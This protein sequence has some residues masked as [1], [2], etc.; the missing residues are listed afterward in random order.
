M[1]T[2]GAELPKLPPRKADEAASTAPEAGQRLGHRADEAVPAEQNEEV[3]PIITPPPVID[4]E[5]V[6]PIEPLLVRLVAAFR[7]I[8]G[9]QNENPIDVETAP[10]R[11]ADEPAPAARES[12]RAC[13]ALR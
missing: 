4:A 6:P 1:S 9:V 11:R 7:L 2:V 5:E 8:F 12:G 13:H 10:A 3:N